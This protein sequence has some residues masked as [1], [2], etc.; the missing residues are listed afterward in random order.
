MRL[1]LRKEPSNYLKPIEHSSF[2]YYVINSFSE[3]LIKI[4][5]ILMAQVA[6]K[7][8]EVEVKVFRKTIFDLIRSFITNYKSSPLCF[9]TFNVKRDKDFL[10]AKRFA[11]EPFTHWK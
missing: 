6:T 4:Y 10:V 5:R 8:D 11:T 1:P 3:L 7:N 2:R 9:L